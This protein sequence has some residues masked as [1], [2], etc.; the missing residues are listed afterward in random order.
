MTLRWVALITIAHLMVACTTTPTSQD[1][2]LEELSSEEEI[3]RLY[4]L[5]QQSESPKSDEYRLRIVDILIELGRIEEAGQILA[6]INPGDLP[7]KTQAI[8][9]V[10]AADFSLASFDAQRALSILDRYETSIRGH[11]DA[12]GVRAIQLKSTA[13][14]MN[15]QP[16]QAAIL[17]TSL[18]SQLADKSLQRNSEA[19][20]AALMEVPEDQ[21]I[22]QTIAPT[23]LEINGWTELATRIRGSQNNVDDQLRALNS[24]LLLWPTHAAAQHLPGELAYLSTMVLEQP[25]KIA[26]IL[27]LGGPNGAAGQAIKDGFLTAYFDAKQLGNRVPDLILIDS[28]EQQDF[29]ALYQGAIAE[30]AELIIGPLEKQQIQLLQDSLAVEIPTLALNYTESEEATPQLYQFGLSAED[31]AV[32]VARKAWQSGEH[33][34]LVISQNSNW[35]IRVSEAFAK[36]WTQLGGVLLETQLF[37]NNRG[38]STTIQELLDIDESERRANRIRA[39]TNTRV[40]SAPRRRQDV[41]FIFMAATPTQ[42]RQIKPTLAFHFAGDLPIFATSHIYSG[43]PNPALDRDLNGI[44]FCET[45]W[46]LGTVDSDLQKTVEKLW[47]DSAQRLG[48]LYAMGIDAFRLY[49]RVRQLSLL[50]TA[51][52]FGATGTLSVLPDGKVSRALNWAQIRSGRIVAIQPSPNLTN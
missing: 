15:N 36:E 44:I 42:A 1:I 21:L 17:L 50:E 27:P 19:I 11:F 31:E 9:A 52:L 40:E 3:Q 24:W 2:L 10:T 48:R 43:E 46:V 5:A 39:I 41:D 25:T 47:P 22:G 18:S 51:R 26:L 7:T 13:L 4:T 20:W 33:S 6:D 38:F 49:P 23:N 34:A 30:G 28:E 45:P 32:Q 12:L 16:L 35:G 37:G 14:R 8:Y 29:L